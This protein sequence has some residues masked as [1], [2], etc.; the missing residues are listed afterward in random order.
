MQNT[1]QTLRHSQTH[2]VTS[3]ISRNTNPGVYQQANH[4][5]LHTN[6]PFNTHTHTH[7]NTPFNTHTHTHTNTPY[8]THTLPTLLT[9]GQA[10][11]RQS[12][13]TVQASNH[14]TPAVEALP[15]PTFFYR[16]TDRHRGTQDT[17][18]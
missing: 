14:A 2:A 10:H 18:Q 16:D 5:Q 4:Q 6:K 3:M 11:T 15:I 9:L 17:R 12:K 13:N 8:N 1:V 7:T